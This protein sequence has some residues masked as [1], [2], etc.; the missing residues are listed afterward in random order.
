VP[1]LARTADRLTQLGYVLFFLRLW[2]RNNWKSLSLDWVG[3]L[4]C[5]TAAMYTH[6]LAIFGVVVPGL[7][8]LIRRDWRFAIRWAGSMAVIALLAVPWLMMIPGQVDKI[9]RAFWTP[10][11]GVAEILQA[12]ILF[13]GNMPLPVM[14]LG[15]ALFLSLIAFVIIGLEGR[16]ERKSIEALGFLAALTTVPPLFLFIISYFMRPVFVTR[17]FLISTLAF[18]ALAA[19]IIHK[20]WQ[21]GGGKLLVGVFVIAAIVSLP[22]QYRYNSFPRSPHREAAAYLQ[23]A[24][25]PHDR[26]IHDNKLSGFPSVI[27][28]PELE[29]VFLADE[30]GSHNDTLA[31][32]SQQAM[33]QYA[34]ADIR[35]AAGDADSVFFVV[36]TQA[37]DEYRAAG[38]QDHPQLNWLNNRYQLADHKVFNDLEVYQFVR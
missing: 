21:R 23:A 4:L 35:T 33:N 32:A 25:G 38:L 26:V 15:V 6:N 29:Q 2:K 12:M 17:G 10:R 20:S 9:Q 14:W 30:T 19:I 31:Y 27:Y 5:G 18:Y 28:A 16:R 8:L 13:T 37:I 22:F 3:L 7:F 34:A 11:P 36:Y 24:A 1:D